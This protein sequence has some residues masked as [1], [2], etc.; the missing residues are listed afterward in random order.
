M[1]QDGLNKFYWGFLFTMVDFKIQGVDVLPDIV[2]YILF[3]IGFGILAANSQHFEKA[4]SFNIPMIILSIFSIYEKPVQGGGVQLG[5]FGLWGVLIGIAATVLN[6]LVVYNLFMGIKD[7]ADQQGKL[8]LSEEAEK[9]W[10]Q[11]LGLQIAALFAFIMIIIPPLAFIWVIALFI[12][13]IIL[14]VVI[15]GFM[16]RCGEGL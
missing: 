2:G 5:T 14:T 10:R 13:A 8:D 3:A 11:Y 1:Y 16:K 7:M 6:L 12:A 9:R 15:M 4:R